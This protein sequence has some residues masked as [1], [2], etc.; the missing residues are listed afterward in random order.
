MGETVV[1][2]EYRP[3]DTSF[4]IISEINEDQEQVDER[5]KVVRTLKECIKKT[6]LRLKAVE[7]AHSNLE[8]K[9]RFLI[10][11]LVWNVRYEAEQIINGLLQ[12]TRVT[13]GSMP[14]T[15]LSIL[16]PDEPRDQVVLL[17]VTN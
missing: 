4:E 10:R 16:K 5:E 1:E 6:I 11:Q 2:S 9:M 15:R 7:V 12:F 13:A 3:D 14:R 17:L 8:E